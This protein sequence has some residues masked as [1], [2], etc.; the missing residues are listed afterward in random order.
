MPKMYSFRRFR[1]TAAIASLAVGSLLVAGCSDGSSA[2]EGTTPDAETSAPEE[3]TPEATADEDGV[4]AGSGLEEVHAKI[5]ALELDTD[6]AAMVPEYFTDRG[7]L[8]VAARSAAPYFVVNPGNEYSGLNVDLNTSIS[9]LLGLEIDY[10]QT[11]SD[12]T[13]PGLQAGRLDMSAPM[14]DFLERQE[15]VDFVD[16][17]KSEV[18][19]LSMVENG[20]N[21]Q[22]SSDLCGYV[23]AIE[24]G[25]ATEKTVARVA[26]NC[27]AAGEE[28][29]T[30][31]SYPDKN[32]AL[33]AV[34]SGRADLLLAP[35][36]SNAAVSNESPD[37][38][39]SEP[40]SDA[41]EFPGGGAIYGIAT[42][43]G[44]GLAEVV[45]AAI[46]RLVEHGIYDEL[47]TA[48]G[49]DKAKLDPAEVI[50]NGG[51]EQVS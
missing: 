49:I 2:P 28:E 14:G 44:N 48:Y 43:K 15:E 30:T 29:P 12:A 33:L 24:Q 31:D 41:L 4:A 27:A 9:L 50:I 34:Q 8:V 20:L 23:V 38:F 16:Y 3:T 36:A 25:A 17:A 35:F 10:L 45:L 40:L 21:I 11:T 22:Q 1:T 26:E 19:A 47:F 18:S 13:V 37:M 7:K 32:A 46:E 5:E 6:L 42:A 39:V 51:S